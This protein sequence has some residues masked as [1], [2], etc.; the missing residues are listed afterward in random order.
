MLSPQVERAVADTED[1]IRRFDQAILEADESS[2]AS[3]AI[4]TSSSK[5]CTK[6]PGDVPL[7][8]DDLIKKFDAAI[9]E[10]LADLETSF[11]NSETAGVASLKKIPA[12]P[13]EEGSLFQHGSNSNN[14]STRSQAQGTNMN[15]PTSRTAPDVSDAEIRNLPEAPS[16]VE[17]KMAMSTPP[18]LETVASADLEAAVPTENAKRNSINSQTM[19]ANSLASMAPIHEGEILDDNAE[20]MS[21]FDTQKLS[22][23]RTEFSGTTPLKRVGT[24]IEKHRTGKKGRSTMGNIVTKESQSWNF[25]SALTSGIKS[26][27]RRETMDGHQCGDDLHPIDFHECFK[28]STVTPEKGLYKFKD[29]APKVFRNLR[30]FFGVDDKAY[31]QSIGQDGLHEISTAETGSKSG[32]KFLI[33]ADGRY[34]MKTITKSECKFFRKILPQYY[35]HMKNSRNTLLCRFF[36]LHRIKPGK[37]HLLVMCNIFDTERV[38]HDRYDLKGSTVGRQVSEA[39]KKN[40]TVI[41]KDLDFIKANGS[42]EVQADC[43]FLQSIG[44]M[45]YSLLLGIHWRE[46][47]V[48]TKEFGLVAHNRTIP[49][50]SAASYWLAAS[51][52]DGL[53]GV[54]RVMLVQIYFMGIIDYLQYYN[55]RKRAETFVKSFQYNYKEISAVGPQL[56]ASRFCDFISSIVE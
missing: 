31:L 3:T 4:Q 15:V 54:A 22:E 21:P 23:I 50:R 43:N 44:V 46:K 35:N 51:G 16:D 18:A 5:V 45:D 24:W 14:R 49:D 11:D 17:I 39:E 9:A 33:S 42:L 7:D 41:L 38:V 26:T 6:S 8:T 56:Y 52:E 53:A 2:E 47:A 55:S 30:Y 10:T 1:I 32:Q 29:Y 27:I 19:K 40:P 13:G 28:S 34:F 20:A 36:G 12:A 25:V 37:L 48:D